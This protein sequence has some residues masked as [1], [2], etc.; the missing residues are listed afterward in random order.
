M[1]SGCSRT[2]LAARV[3]PKIILCDL[4]KVHF[5]KASRAALSYRFSRV[6][7]LVNKN[8]HPLRSRAVS[9]DSAARLARSLDL[10]TML[11]SF[12]AVQFVSTPNDQIGV[13]VVIAVLAENT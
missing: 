12:H 8:A 13:A 11:T 4:R 3:A 6:V 5:G 10:Y 1:Q 2:Q 7:N 9:I